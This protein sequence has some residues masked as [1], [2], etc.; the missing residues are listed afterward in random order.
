M[1]KGRCADVWRA[2]VEGKHVD[3]ARGKGRLA[4]RWQV[5]DLKDGRREKN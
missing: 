2:G 3:P 4:R 1:D 5:A